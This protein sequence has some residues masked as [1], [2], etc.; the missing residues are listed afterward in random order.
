VQRQGIALVQ[1]T[2]AAKTV[3]TL[4]ENSAAQ[5]NSQGA[6]KSQIEGGVRRSLGLNLTKRRKYRTGK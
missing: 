2:K 3:Q 4:V 6:A 5:T 1:E